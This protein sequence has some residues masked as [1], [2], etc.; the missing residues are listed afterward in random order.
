MQRVFYCYFSFCISSG[1]SC[2]EN[3][4]KLGKPDDGGFGNA[5]SP[6]RLWHNGDELPLLHVNNSSGCDV[7]AR[8]IIDYPMLS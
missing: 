7:I 6:C 3:A 2:L 8:G 5:N 4:T 1:K